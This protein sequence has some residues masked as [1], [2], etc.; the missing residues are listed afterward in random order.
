[1][2]NVA[3]KKSLFKHYFKEEREFFILKDD[4]PSSPIPLLAFLIKK[5]YEEMVFS[6][7]DFFSYLEKFS[8]SI[9]KNENIIFLI[10]FPLLEYYLGEEGE[11]CIYSRKSE[12]DS[13]YFIANIYKTDKSLTITCE[14]L[15]YSRA[16]KKGQKIIIKIKPKTKK[17]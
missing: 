12:E 14:K 1:M 16:S 4:L 17:K 7:K 8:N 13:G 5:E 10:D 2:K 6:R 9:P 11:T 15:G 3:A